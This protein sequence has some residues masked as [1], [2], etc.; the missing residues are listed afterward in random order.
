MNTKR[1]NVRGKSIDQIMNLVEKTIDELLAENEEILR[2]QM[3]D[4]GVSLDDAD[5]CVRAG[6]LRKRNGE[7][8]H[9]PR[10]DGFLA[11]ANVE[12]LI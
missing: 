11:V 2:I 1:W 9:S 8:K 4:G 12:Q 3:F 7:R 5:A 6:V 10:C